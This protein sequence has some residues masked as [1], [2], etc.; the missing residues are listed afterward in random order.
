MSLDKVML[1]VVLSKK[2][3]GLVAGGGLVDDLRGDYDMSI[4]RTCRIELIPRSLY[5]LTK[6]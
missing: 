4:R 2:L 1:Q 5:L 3:R 6:N